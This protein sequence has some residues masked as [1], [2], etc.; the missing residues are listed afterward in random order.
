MQLCTLSII[1]RFLPSLWNRKKPEET[2]RPPRLPSSQPT[3]RTQTIW[4]SWSFRG[5]TPRKPA[6]SLSHSLALNEHCSFQQMLDRCIRM[7]SNPTPGPPLRWSS[8]I[9]PYEST[10]KT[11]NQRVCAG[12]E[13]RDRRNASPPQWSHLS[14][15]FARAWPAS[16][17]PHTGNDA[18]RVNCRNYWLRGGERR[19]W[20]KK[21]D[22]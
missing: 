20:G 18:M 21:V 19:R 13:W 15:R 10:I 17:G 22:R 6:H 11:C 4:I 5:S 2:P 3:F 8:R 12:R 7:R 9:Q 14:L 1:S 16:S